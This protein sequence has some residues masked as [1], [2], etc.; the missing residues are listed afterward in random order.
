MKKLPTTIIVL[1]FL[2][3]LFSFAHAELGFKTNKPVPMRVEPQQVPQ[4]SQPAPSSTIEEDKGS[5][6]IQFR[7]FKLEAVMQSLDNETGIEFKIPAYM[8]S[9][10]VTVNV[11]ADNWKTAVRKIFSDYSHVKVWTDKPENSRV[12]LMASTPLPEETGVMFTMDSFIV[13]LAGSGGKRFLKV[14]V[15]LELSAPE[16]HS[17]LKGN[18]QKITNSILLLLSS[19]TFED[20]YSVQGKFKLKDEITARVN[21]FLLTGHVKGTYF[22][23]FIIQ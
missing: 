9:E 5:I 6:S 16:V 11:K 2:L 19:K 21:R 3:I 8:A 18:I 15:S 12:W 1:G 14:T 22:T 17:E 7:D 13:N 10:L 4:F 20:V 23:E